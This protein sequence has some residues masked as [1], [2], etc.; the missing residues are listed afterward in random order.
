MH[1]G[2]RI[3]TRG[4][5]CISS[6]SGNCI[7][8]RHTRSCVSSRD[9]HSG[10]RIITSGVSCVSR[11][12][13]YCI[14]WRHTRSTSPSLNRILLSGLGLSQ[15]CQSSVGHCD[16]LSSSGSGKTCVVGCA[17]LSRTVIDADGVRQSR[18]KH[19]IIGGWTI[20]ITDAL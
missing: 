6:G 7:G 3:I 12:G 8:W 16:S 19:N 1:G 15:L 18:R 5:R 9:V 2:S 13:G 17:S 10:S 4:V 20:I 11:G 14:N